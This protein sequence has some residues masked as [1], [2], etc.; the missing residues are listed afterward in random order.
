VES[1]E[2]NEAPKTRSAK[3]AAKPEPE[4]ENEPVQ[5]KSAAG[6]KSSASSWRKSTSEVRQP[7]P[8]FIPCTQN[9]TSTVVC[10]H[11]AELIVSGEILSFPQRSR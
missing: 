10:M 8:S 9:A 3:K 2:V 6:R 4:K 1:E 11:R 5:K 7:S